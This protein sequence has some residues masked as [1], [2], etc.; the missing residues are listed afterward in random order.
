MLR[1][2]SQVEVSCFEVLRVPFSSIV[3]KPYPMRAVCC[4]DK[5]IESNYL[6][7]PGNASTAHA[8][9]GPFISLYSACRRSFFATVLQFCVF[10]LGFREENG[11]NAAAEVAMCISSMD[12]GGGGEK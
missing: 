7:V 3:L 9:Q 11:Q 8:H 4:L 2:G 1:T 12:D 6:A 10:A 5:P